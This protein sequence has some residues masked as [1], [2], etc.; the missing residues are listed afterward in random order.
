MKIEF[1]LNIHNSF[2]RQHGL[3]VICEMGVVVQKMVP[4]ETAG[5]LFTCHPVTGNSGEMVI[6]S[7][8]GLGEVKI[9]QY[10]EYLH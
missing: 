3:P 1:L 7:N 10:Y 5:V 2:N 9:K 8:Y 6:T 4:S